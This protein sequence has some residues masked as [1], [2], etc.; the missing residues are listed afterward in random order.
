MKNL[1]KLTLLHSNDLLLMLD[2]EVE[3][4]ITMLNAEP[5]E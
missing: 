3:G 1:K 2:Q 5:V 4:R